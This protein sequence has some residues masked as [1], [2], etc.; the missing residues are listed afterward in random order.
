MSVLPSTKTAAAINIVLA[1][2]R[3]HNDDEPRE[4]IRLLEELR[5]MKFCRVRA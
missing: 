4:L 1:I 2:E 3:A 5:G